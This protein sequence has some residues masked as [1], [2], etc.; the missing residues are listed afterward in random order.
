MLLIAL[1]AVNNSIRALALKRR[2]TSKQIDD[3]GQTI[4]EHISQIREEAR[5]LGER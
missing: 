2:L 1:V 3:Y 5:G 4:G